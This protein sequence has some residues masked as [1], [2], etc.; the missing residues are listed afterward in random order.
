MHF[1]KENSSS[2]ANRQPTTTVQAFYNKIIYSNVLASSTDLMNYDYT[3]DSTR[4]DIVGPLI[5]LYIQYRLTYHVAIVLTNFGAFEC[6]TCKVY[7]TNVTT[8]LTLA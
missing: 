2:G 7:L 5:I 8:D 1:S 4:G 3:T 6:F